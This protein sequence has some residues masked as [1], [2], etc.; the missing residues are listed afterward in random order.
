[1]QDADAAD[2]TQEVMMSVAHAIRSF[3][4]D[5][6]RGG[7]RHWLLTIVRN[8]LRNFWRK[9]E[10]AARGTGGTQAHEVLM[11]QPETSNGHTTD[12][13]QAYERQLFQ[14]A[15][16]Q[17]RQDFQESTWLAFWRTAVEGESAKEVS[18]DLGMSVAA[19]YMAKR[20]VVERIREQIVFLE[21]VSK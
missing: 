9:N 10:S 12:W 11:E 6:E 2:L 20:R 19:V 15:A 13:D 14:F 1:V 8:Q 17:V 7:F 4:Y 21:G 3:E 16:D 18:K 5:P